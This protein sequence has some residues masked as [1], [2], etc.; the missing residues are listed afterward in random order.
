M[1]YAEVRIARNLVDALPTS[2]LVH[3]VPILRHVHG[4]QAVTVVR[5]YEVKDKTRDNEPADVVA[6]AERLTRK[7]GAEVGQ[8]S[9]FLRAYGPNED[10]A[11]GSLAAA[12]GIKPEAKPG[13]DLAA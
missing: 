10:S 8:P 5:E 13:A 2:V 1:K 11:L 7:Y 3:E 4:A 12:M 6:E 9:F